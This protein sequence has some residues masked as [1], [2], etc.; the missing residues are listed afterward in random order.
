MVNVRV[1]PCVTRRRDVAC[2]GRVAARL[3]AMSVIWSWG[4][5]S[6]NGT[7]PITG[8]SFTLNWE[9]LSHGS[10]ACAL[11]AAEWC[12]PSQVDIECQVLCAVA[13]D[14]FCGSMCGHASVCHTLDKF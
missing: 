2:Y 4:D 13:C 10:A 11:L 5:E 12:R 3:S 9:L 6:E 14:A 1:A 7:N 8:I